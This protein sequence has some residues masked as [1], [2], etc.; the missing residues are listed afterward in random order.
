MFNASEGMIFTTPMG[1]VKIKDSDQL[2]DVCIS[3]DIVSANRVTAEH[4]DVLEGIDKFIDS[5]SIQIRGAVAEWVRASTGDQTVDG[6]SPTSVKTFRFGTLA[7]PFT[8][9][10]Q[11]LSDETVKAV[12]VPSIW[13]LCQGK[14]KIP[15]VRTGMCNSWTPPPILNPPEVRLCG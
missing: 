5:Y 3:R 4:A 12:V 13:C 11:C 6:S 7:I 10:C 1:V 9:L 14:Y 2:D 15:P 8:P